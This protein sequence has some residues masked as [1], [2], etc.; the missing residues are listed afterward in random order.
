MRVALKDSERQAFN[1]QSYE[2]QIRELTDQCHDYD[3]EVMEYKEEI[4]KLNMI[5][6]KLYEEL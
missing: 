5:S 2:V 1:C 6:Q 3:I 4:E